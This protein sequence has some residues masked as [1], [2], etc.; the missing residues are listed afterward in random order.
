MA[1]NAVRECEALTII[2]VEHE[3]FMQLESFQQ[4]D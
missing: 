1:G 3:E 2:G 4:K